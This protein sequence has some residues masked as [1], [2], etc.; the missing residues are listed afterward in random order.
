MDYIHSEFYLGT[1]DVVEV[2]LD[3]QANVIL[4]DT[5]NYQSYRSRRSFEYFGGLATESPVHLQPPHSGHWHLVIDLG[6][7]SGT[8]RHSVKVIK[9]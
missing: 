2:A 9:Q 4:L 5:S 1:D 8:L 7:G 3:K 6:G